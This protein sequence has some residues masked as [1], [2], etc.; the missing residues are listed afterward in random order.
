MCVPS[1][2]C[3]ALTCKNRLGEAHRMTAPFSSAYGIAEANSFVSLAPLNRTAS[4][5][6]KRCICP[7]RR[8]EHRPR[9]WYPADSGLPFPVNGR[10]PRFP[11]SRAPLNNPALRLAPLLLVLLTGCVPRY[12]VTTERDDFAQRTVTRMEDNL[13]HAPGGGRDW[14]ALNAEQVQSAGDSARYVLALEYRS[15]DGWL[16]IRPGASL[17]LLAD[18]QRITLTGARSRRTRGPFGAHEEVRYPTTRALLERLAAARE[19]RVRVLGSRYYVDRSFSEANFKR[20]R[21]FLNPADSMAAPAASP[22]APGAPVPTPPA[23]R[24]TPPPPPQPR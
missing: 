17:L 11:R 15:T 9:P 14:V 21:R 19:V 22:M 16:R 3:Q 8:G 23:P 24:P 5:S 20:L 12:R 18:S 7:S 4:G 6:C 10:P 13:L 2:S 1:H